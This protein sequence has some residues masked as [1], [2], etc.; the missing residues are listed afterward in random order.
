MNNFNYIQSMSLEQLAT[1]LDINGQCD[2]S[3]WLN[4]FSANYCKKCEPVICKYEDVEAKLGFESF[5][6]RDCE[7]AYCELEERCRYFSTYPTSLEIIKLWLA[8]SHENEV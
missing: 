7:C 2:D 3:P 1:W 4:W 6:G 8:A 5:F